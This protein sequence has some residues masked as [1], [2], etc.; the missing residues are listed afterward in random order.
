[1]MSSLEH[2][3]DLDQ[4]SL[5]RQG[6]KGFG[7]ISLVPEDIKRLVGMVRGLPS[8]LALAIGQSTKARDFVFDREVMNS[9]V[10]DFHL[11][12][13]MPHGESAL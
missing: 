10:N 7:G 9:I 4:G 3:P 13:E 6:P 8:G 5:P 1:M 12:F 2:R 11:E